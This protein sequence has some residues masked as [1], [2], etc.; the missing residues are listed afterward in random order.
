MRTFIFIKTTKRDGV[1]RKTIVGMEQGDL[2]PSAQ[3]DPDSCF[4]NC[5]CREVAENCHIELGKFVE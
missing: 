5:D 3:N 1:L 4:Y 2:F